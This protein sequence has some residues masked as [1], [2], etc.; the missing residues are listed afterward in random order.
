MTSKAS[1]DRFFSAANIVVV[2]V[3]GSGKKFGAAVYRELKKKGVHV[4]GVN[5]KGGAIDGDTLHASL[6]ALPV[7]PDAAVIVVPPKVSDQIVK[8]A[9]N[10]GVKNIWL[11]PGAESDTAIAF[12]ESSGLNVIHGECILM[13]AAP[14][15]SIHK[16]H[17]F[18]NKIF[19]KL[20]R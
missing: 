15:E 7:K 16:V 10:L 8:E 12:C 4:F 1:V 20:P 3:S 17:R 2:G 6:R 14:V 9:H 13:H 5:A 11:Q 19:G 18:I